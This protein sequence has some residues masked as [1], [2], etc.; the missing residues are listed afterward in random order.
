[1]QGFPSV[2]SVEGR[3]GGDGGSPWP[4]LF[5]QKASQLVGRTSRHIALLLLFS[6]CPRGLSG[7]KDETLTG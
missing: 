7:F 6:A 4:V 5:P 1:M 2:H 3:Q